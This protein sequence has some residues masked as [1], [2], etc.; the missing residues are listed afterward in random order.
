MTKDEV[1]GAT[2]HIGPTIYAEQEHRSASPNYPQYPWSQLDRFVNPSQICINSPFVEPHLQRDTNG[3][4]EPE[5]EV[6][7]GREGV[8]KRTQQDRALKKIELTLFATKVVQQSRSGKELLLGCG[9]FGIPRL[10]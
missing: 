1:K 8:L 3:I 6:L 9:I 10:K 5:A 2:L 7:I 4:V